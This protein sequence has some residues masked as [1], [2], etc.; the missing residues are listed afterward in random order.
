MA[1]KN[2][3]ILQKLL[4]AGLLVLTAGAGIRLLPPPVISKEEMDRA[5]LIM[6]E[7][8]AE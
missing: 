1:D 8:L 7:T 4:R 2:S 5:L 3:E 6:K